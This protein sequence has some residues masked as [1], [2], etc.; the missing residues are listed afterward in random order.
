MLDKATLI[1]SRHGLYLPTNSGLRKFSSLDEVAKEYRGKKIV[2]LVA[3]N[4]SY[5]ENLSFSSSKTITD[6]DLETE[7][8]RH[9]P[10]PL[11]ENDWSTLTTSKTGDQRRLVAFVL[12]PS[13]FAEFR[14]LMTERNLTIEHFGS[15]ALAVNN[16]VDDQN[17]HLIVFV[18][19]SLYFMVAKIGAEIFVRNF[20]QLSQLKSVLGEFLVS[21][22]T[23]KQVTIAKIY[24]FSDRDLSSL[25]LKFQN[26][27]IHYQKLKSPITVEPNPSTKLA[28]KAG[29][30][31][32]NVKPT[33]EKHNPSQLI[34]LL[35][36][37]VISLATMGG[38]FWWRFGQPNKTTPL[39]S[40]SPLVLVETL[41]PSPS[42]LVPGEVFLT[43][44]NGTGQRGY[45][46]EVGEILKQ[47]GFSQITVG[48]D[49]G[50][51]SKNIIVSS[52]EEINAAVI[53]ALPSFQF[54]SLTSTPSGAASKSATIYLEKVTE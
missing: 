9:V 30:N 46:S 38:V 10:G 6:A 50:T 45:A 26:L 15:L 51:Y 2:A 32:T 22:E 1:I 35:A 40:P 8:S 41:N 43:I 12:E 14:D 52:S 47:V 25:G 48:N 36:L 4:L 34:K 44:L 13:F 54:D 7:L 3:P 21:L 23:N 37:L 53:K 33:L 11:H 18:Q 5:L 28:F 31:G 27:P 39:P 29:R 24:D 16:L 19:N 42:P 49:R 20:D 17:P